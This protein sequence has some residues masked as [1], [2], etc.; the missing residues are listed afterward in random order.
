MNL[1]TKT[2]EG[3]GECGDGCRRQLKGAAR[4]SRPSNR[5]T[6]FTL[7]D[8]APTLRVLAHG[9]ANANNQHQRVICEPASGERCAGASTRT[10]H[11]KPNDKMVT[12]DRVPTKIG[13]GARGVHSMTV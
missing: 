3:Q 7:P 8:T 9:C 10:K 1:T 6:G 11:T 13:K 12:L 5:Y 4:K 2:L